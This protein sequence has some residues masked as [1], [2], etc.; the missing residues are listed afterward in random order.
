MLQERLLSDE[1]IA[2][3]NLAV[4]AQGNKQIKYDSRYFHLRPIKSRFYAYMEKENNGTTQQ[5]MIL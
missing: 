3:Q 5:I 2:S 1:K 4:Q